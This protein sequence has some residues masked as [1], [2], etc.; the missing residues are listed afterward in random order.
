MDTIP[1]NLES[2]SLFP[3]F[4]CCAGALVFIVHV[5]EDTNS[6]EARCTKCNREWYLELT[7]GHHNHLHNHDGVVLHQPVA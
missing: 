2:S 7:N 4:R 1:E 6:W 3:E 5:Y